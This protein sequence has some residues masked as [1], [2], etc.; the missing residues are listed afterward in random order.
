MPQRNPLSRYGADMGRHMPRHNGDISTNPR[1]THVHRTRIT[2]QINDHTA[3]P[4]A[5]LSECATTRQTLPT[6]GS[7]GFHISCST[8]GLTRTSTTKNK[9]TRARQYSGTAGTGRHTRV[10]EIL[11]NAHLEG[12]GALQRLPQRRHLVGL[13]QPPKPAKILTTEAQQ[14]GISK[15]QRQN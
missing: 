1:N 12:R 14:V 2:Q 3:A 13:L 6:V 4:Q 15:P 5:K 11:L 9:S 7:K 10:S 8:T